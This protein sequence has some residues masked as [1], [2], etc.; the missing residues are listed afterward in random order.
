VAFGAV[1]DEGGLE[2]GLD[3]GN[4]PFVN[5]G[6]F[7]CL[8]GD[9]DI[10]IV[11]IPWVAF[12]SIRFMLIHPLGRGTPCSRRS[13]DYRAISG[14]RHHPVWQRKR[15]RGRN[16]QAKDGMPESVDTDCGKP[17]E[18]RRRPI[19]RIPRT[20]ARRTGR[21]VTRRQIHPFSPVSPAVRAVHP[22]CFVASRAARPLVPAPTTAVSRARE[23]ASLV[24]CDAAPPLT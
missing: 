10:E 24:A 3:A 16:R 9:L 15:W 17:D 12:I 2:A 13:L 20:R 6:L 19:G 5:A 14:L 4:F 18:R 1:V 11:Q 7:L 23:F 8:G 22:E 21:R